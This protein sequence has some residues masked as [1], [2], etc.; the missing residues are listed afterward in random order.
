[1]YSEAP[2]LLQFSWHKTPQLGNCHRFFSLWY[3]TVTLCLHLWWET[4]VMPHVLHYTQPHLK[5]ND[6]HSRLVVKKEQQ[7]TTTY[8]SECLSE[9]VCQGETAILGS[10]SISSGTILVFSLTLYR[11]RGIYKFCGVVG[12]SYVVCI[13]CHLSFLKVHFMLPKYP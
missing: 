2:L 4:D 12:S 7:S 9:V 3:C 10:I 5:V 1:M 13:R 6:F 8:E 11:Y